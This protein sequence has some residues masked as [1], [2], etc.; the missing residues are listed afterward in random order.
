M[1]A[2]RQIVKALFQP[3]LWRRCGVEHRTCR[4]ISIVITLRSYP[5]NRILWIFSS[6]PNGISARFPHVSGKQNWL[7]FAI[8][9]SDVCY[10]LTSCKKCTDLMPFCKPID[11]QRYF[12]F[13]C[14]CYC[15]WRRSASRTLWGFALPK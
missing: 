6:P 5:E 3:A 10:Y 13:A 14:C 1:S 4:L 8:S 12:I 15:R 7:P 11:G 2:K 9:S